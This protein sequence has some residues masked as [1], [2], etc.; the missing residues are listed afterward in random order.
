MSQNLSSAAVVIG[1]LRVKCRIYLKIYNLPLTI[2]LLMSSAENLCKQ[3]GPRSGPTTCRARSGS[4]MFD[5]LMVILKEFFKNVDLKKK[6]ADN[7]KIKAPQA[8]RNTPPLLGAPK[9]IL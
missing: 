5:S 9:V 2:C 3:Y 6:S 1:A 8:L 7:Y 4:N